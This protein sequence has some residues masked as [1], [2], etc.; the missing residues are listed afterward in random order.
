M[1]LGSYFFARTLPPW[2]ERKRLRTD[3]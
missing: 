1:A 2:L 3:A